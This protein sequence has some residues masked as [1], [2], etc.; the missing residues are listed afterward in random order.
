MSPPHPGS[1]TGSHAPLGRGMVA[2]AGVHGALLAL[3]LWVGN[4]PEAARPPVY[5]VELVG[6]A[7]VRQAGVEKPT[8][9]A[10]PSADPVAGAERVAEEK[11]VPAPS[12]AK[13]AMPSPKATPSTDRSKKGGAK[14]EPKPNAK[15]STAAPKSGAG[16]TGTKGADV[17]NVRT[18]GIAF[19]FPGYLS[20]IVRQIALN[21]SPRRT[22]AAL[23]TELKF[24]I[25]RD[26]SV[27]GIEVVTRSG[28]RLYDLDAMGAIEAVGSSR[29][30]GALP[31]GWSDDV[32]VVYFTF[33][34]ALRPK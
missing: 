20:N 31:S 1:M 26:G 21:W 2:S 33:D 25:R 16:A 29:S 32:L 18:D 12:K 24:M 5:R 17:A 27:A 4:R 30:F 15:T 14:A 23:V 13:K 11:T 22:S 19:P 10:A 6:Q 8:E 34:Y 7:G 9:E 3:V 28:D